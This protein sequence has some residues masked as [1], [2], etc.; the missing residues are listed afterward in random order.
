MNRGVFPVCAE[1]L[2][3]PPVL[4]PDLELRFPFFLPSSHKRTYCV[5]KPMA[6]CSVCLGDEESPQCLDFLLGS[7][8]QAAWV[9]I[10]GILLVG[11][12]LGQGQASRALRMPLKRP[13][14]L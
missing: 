4:H 1:S 2:I 9:Y 12:R 11:S 13:G 5:G 10:H 7:G 6:P 3:L 8:L 14:C